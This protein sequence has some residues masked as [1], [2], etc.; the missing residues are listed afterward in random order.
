MRTAEKMIIPTHMVGNVF[1]LL[2]FTSSSCMKP[3]CG[4]S[5][6]LP[7]N[8]FDTKICFVTSS[9]LGYDDHVVF[10]MRWVGRGPPSPFVTILA[11]GWV[12]FCFVP[13]L[14]ETGKKLSFIHNNDAVLLLNPISCY[15]EDNILRR[16]ELFL[17]MILVYFII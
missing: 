9:V 8:Y 16:L 12:D 4:T 2:S 10:L 3:L 11:G 15:I 5:P 13:Y 17:M 6:L 7:T 1:P 14:P